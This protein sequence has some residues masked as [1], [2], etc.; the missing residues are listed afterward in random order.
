[1]L[2]NDYMLR[3]PITI[4]PTKRALDARHVMA[5]QAVEFLPVVGDGR[6]LQGLVTPSCLEISPERLASL[7]VWEI[8]RYLSHLTVAK[9]MIKREALHYIKP[10]ATLEDAAS[11]M[12]R[13][14]VGGLPVVE[15]QDLVVVGMITSADLLTELRNLLG[16]VEPGWRVT[17]RVPGNHGELVRLTRE[18]SERGWSIM[19]MGNVRSLRSPKHWDIVLKIWGCTRE[20]LVAAIDQ[21]ASQEIVDIRETSYTTGG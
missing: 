18:F 13:H 20:E 4:E 15:G 17:V 8:T 9:V 16:A 6:R 1:M 11:L 2:V 21:Q 5:E 3:H 14:K 12:I 19:A 7:D 10:Q